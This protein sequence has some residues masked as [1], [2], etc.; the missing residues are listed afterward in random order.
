MVRELYHR[1]WNRIGV[2]VHP[3]YF[4]IVIIKIISM[5]INFIFW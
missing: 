2:F 1:S 4:F 5:E 3:H